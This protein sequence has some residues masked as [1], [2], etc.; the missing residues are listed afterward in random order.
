MDVLELDGFGLTILPDRLCE[1]QEGSS[2][3]GKSIYYFVGGV[4]WSSARI[5]LVH[6]G[7]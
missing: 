3:L 4:S 2:F 1:H 7:D 5:M 6:E